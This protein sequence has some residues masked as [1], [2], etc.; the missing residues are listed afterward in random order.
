M[1]ARPPSSSAPSRNRRL[2]PTRRQVSPQLMSPAARAAHPAAPAVH[3]APRRSECRMSS[4]RTTSS[5]RTR[6][7]LLASTTWMRR[8]PPAKGACSSTT[9]TGRLSHS[10]PPEVLLLIP[11]RGF[12]CGRRRTMS[13]RFPSSVA[14]V[15]AAFALLFGGC[16]GGAKAGAPSDEQLQSVAPAVTAIPSECLASGGAD[17]TGLQRDVDALVKVFRDTDPDAKFKL[18]PSGPDVT[19]RQL[20]T[21]SRD[22]LQA[23]A[24]AGR[25]G[26]AQS[27]VDRV[28]SELDK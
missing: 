19:M 9:A 12:C 21:Q 24:Q 23:C 26:A 25:S 2:P 7:R 15:L 18:V 10:P 6:C 1:G 28:N 4:G 3:P 17:D 27:L 14:F 20:L 22:A 16:G 13:R 8:T 11:T 5:L